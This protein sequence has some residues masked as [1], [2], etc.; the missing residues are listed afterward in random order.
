MKKTIFILT[1]LIGVTLL[2][3]ACGSNV[4]PPAPTQD[5][6]ISALQTQLAEM[7]SNIGDLQDE[8]ADL[9]D[10]L[11]E[12]LATPEVTEEPIPTDTPE[13]TP[14]PK[15][16]GVFLAEGKI[17][18]MKRNK[19]G[20]IQRNSAGNPLHDVLGANQVEWFYKGDRTCVYKDWIQFDGGRVW[21]LWYNTLFIPTGEWLSGNDCCF[22]SWNVFK[23]D[24]ASYTLPLETK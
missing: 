16:C 5:P 2:L 22:V 15:R 18:Q 19:N 12:A 4:E 21:K 17:Y 10:Q 1:V 8:N 24:D 23:P 14:E 7:S 20:V 11:E 6:A 13:P 3:V 9:Q